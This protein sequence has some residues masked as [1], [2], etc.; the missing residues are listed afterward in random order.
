MLSLNQ[1]EQSR[2]SVFVYTGVMNVLLKESVDM[3]STLRGLP[4]AAGP[5]GHP[6]LPGAQGEPGSVGAPGLPG[7][8]GHDGAV[9]ATGPAG[10]QGKHKEIAGCV[11]NTDSMSK[12]SMHKGVKKHH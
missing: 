9:G 1:S 8:P 11:K 2:F 4:G 5:A 3:N 7:P 12:I 6:G 10:L